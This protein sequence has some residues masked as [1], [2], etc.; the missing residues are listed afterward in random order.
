LTVSI[1]TPLG[2]TVTE[3]DAHTSAASTAGESCHIRWNA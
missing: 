1:R 3:L 2:R